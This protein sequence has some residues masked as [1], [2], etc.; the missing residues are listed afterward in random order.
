[1]EGLQKPPSIPKASYRNTPRL[2]LILGGGGARAFS[3]TGVLKALEEERIPVHAIVGLEWG[4]LMAGLFAKEG[5]VHSLEWQLYKLDEDS[6][7]QKGFL[8]RAFSTSSI[9]SMESY[10]NTSFGKAR[11][12]NSKIKFSCPTVSLQN[13]SV[14]WLTRGSTKI[15]MQSCIA[16]PPI[17]GGDSNRAAAPYPV[18]AAA[19][20]L[21]RQGAQVVVFVDVLSEGDIWRSSDLPKDA[22]SRLLWWAI[23]DHYQQKINGVDEVLRVNASSIGMSDFEKRKTAVQLGNQSGKALTQ[24]LMRNYQF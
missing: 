4:A 15:A 11:V 18:E 21:R 24:K 6:L 13:G 20:W 8:A 17:F 22:S 7:P 10:F 2:G 5:S 9:S 3:H 12:E 23:R 1:D 16:F 14:S 19:Q